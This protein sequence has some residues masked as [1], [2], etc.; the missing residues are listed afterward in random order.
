MTSKLAPYTCTH[1]PNFLGLFCYHLLW[2]LL[3]AYTHY[4][5]ISTYPLLRTFGCLFEFT[6]LNHTLCYI[7]CFLIIKYYFLLKSPNPNPNPDPNP[8]PQTSTLL[9]WIQLIH[10]I[11]TINQFLVTVF[12]WL[13]INNSSLWYIKFI[14][15][16]W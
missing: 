1:I 4:L 16:A 11:L 6:M 5:R 8:N 10:P 9:A 14:H 12:Y 13:F 15:G 7:Y 2:L 3:A